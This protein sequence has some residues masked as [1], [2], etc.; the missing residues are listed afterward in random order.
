MNDYNFF[1][2]KIDQLEIDNREQFVM[3]VNQ[4]NTILQHQRQLDMI[5]IILKDK[6]STHEQRVEIALELISKIK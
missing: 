5:E 6:H 3:L 2:E 1:E 4:A